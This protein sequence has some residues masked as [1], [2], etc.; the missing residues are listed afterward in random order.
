MSA[1]YNVAHQSRVILRPLFQTDITCPASLMLTVLLTLTD[2][3][4]LLQETNAFCISEQ[5]SLQVTTP[6]A[7]SRLRK[8]QHCSQLRLRRHI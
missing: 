6:R 4:H 8:S 1:T 7:S 5:I 3:L 2:L